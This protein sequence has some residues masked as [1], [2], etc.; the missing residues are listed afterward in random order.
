MGGLLGRFFL[1]LDDFRVDGSSD[2]RPRPLGA[3][4]DLG[5]PRVFPLPLPL[6]VVVRPDLGVKS[7]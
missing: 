4:L 1:G 7:S 2:G 5:L 3:P 6:T